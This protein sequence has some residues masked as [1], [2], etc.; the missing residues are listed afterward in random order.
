[1]PWQHC[2]ATAL[3]LISTGFS[4]LGHID[5]SANL[6]LFAAEQLFEEALHLRQFIVC[7]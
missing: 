6:H 5:S 4:S 2:L 3:F 7:G 1:M